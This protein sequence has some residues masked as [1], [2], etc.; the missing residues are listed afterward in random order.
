MAELPFLVVH[1][2]WLSKL[3]A[4]VAAGAASTSVWLVRWWRDGRRACRS[5]RERARYA[6]SP[7]PGNVALRAVWRDGEGRAW[8]DCDGERV[9][10]DGEPRVVRGTR[11]RWRWRWR[12]AV[13]I[14]GG[15]KLTGDRRSLDPDG[16][17]VELQLREDASPVGLGLPEDDADV[18]YPPTSAYAAL[19]SGV[20]AESLHQAFTDSS[21]VPEHRAA[22][23]AAAHGDADPLAALIERNTVSWFA[24]AGVLVT[25]IPRIVVHRE[26][27]DAVW[28]TSTAPSMTEVFTFLSRLAMHRDLARTIGDLATASRCQE[29]L[30]R[31][32]AALADRNKLIALLLLDL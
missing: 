16:L 9:E 15:S 20:V 13:A 5:A 28:L 12:D 26:R 24:A 19:R 6:S 10:F 23:L 32:A 30:A 25:V 21:A 8:L 31:Y 7:S 18:R 22:L 11:V 3:S 2:G 27:L 14:H 17:D 4:I 1:G 29:I